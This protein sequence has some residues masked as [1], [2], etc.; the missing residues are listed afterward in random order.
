MERGETS[1]TTTWP[2]IV[3]FVFGLLHGFGFAGA[4]VEVGLPRGDIPLALV[5]FNLGVEIGQLAFIALLLTPV[6]TVRRLVTIPRRGD[7]RLSLRYR[8]RRRVL[9]RRAA[10]RDVSMRTDRDEVSRT[11]EEGSSLSWQRR[12]AWS[13]QRLAQKALHAAMKTRSQSRAAL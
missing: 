5:S 6:Y 10:G 1:L 2:W 3:A 11:S 12:R 9:E 8:H 4:L 13:P 7:R